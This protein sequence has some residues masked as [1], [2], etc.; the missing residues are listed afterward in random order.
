MT[1][2]LG[3]RDSPVLRIAQNQRGLGNETRKPVLGGPLIYVGDFVGPDD[4]S[5]DPLDA[6][7]D[8]PPWQ[9]GFTYVLGYPV[10]F[11][12]GVDGET[13]MGGM[14]DLFTGS[15][16]SGDVAFTMPLEWAN[17]AAVAASFPVELDTGVWTLAVQSIDQSTG[18]VRI[19]WPICGD[20]CVT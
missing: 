15:P 8:S 10:W 19:F 6:S 18:D 16:V 11:A 2:P 7:P 4:P 14:Y 5:N 20:L 12:H 17:S 3:I 13:D 1:R 9:N